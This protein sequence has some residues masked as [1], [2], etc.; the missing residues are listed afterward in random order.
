MEYGTV[1]TVIGVVLLI[2][3]TLFLTR[4]NWFPGAKKSA[5]PQQPDQE[6]P[7]SENGD[8]K[9]ETRWTKIWTF[10]QH[11]IIFIAIGIGL[12]NW[13]IWALSHSFWNSLW[14]NQGVFW[15]INIGSLLVCG[16][17]LIKR[18]DGETRPIASTLSIMVG[19][20]VCIIFVKAIVE[21]FERSGLSKTDYAEKMRIEEPLRREVILRAICI[22]ESGCQQFNA[23]G[24][25]KHGDVNPDDI[26]MFQ[27]NKRIHANLIK[28][29]GLNPEVTED[30]I[31][32]AEI[33]LDRYGT[34]PW[35]ASEKLWIKELEKLSPRLSKP[36]VLAV[37]DVPTDEWSEEV[38]NP[39]LSGTNIVWGRLDR[40]KGGEC[41][42]MLDRDPKK[43]FRITETHNEFSPKEF[44]FKCTE[45][46]A[47]MRVQVVPR[48]E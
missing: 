36:F 43:V 7:A 22:A 4:D 42:V 17:L 34:E 45:Q 8:K 32:L 19:I 15:A 1:F 3:L 23:D 5:P 35:K 20:L 2:G 6:A 38:N 27:I 48:R 46:S 28:K 24:S 39:L 37:V 21:N 30:N 29:T 44:Q 12:V 33:L 41:K 47:Q 11:P 14:D 40:G 9:K 13:L 10:V 31:R 16:L 18:T 25:V 26:G